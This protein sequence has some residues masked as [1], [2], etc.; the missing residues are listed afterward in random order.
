[1]SK[2]HKT[3][4]DWREG[5]KRRMIA[6]LAEAGKLKREAFNILRASSQARRADGVPRHVDGSRSQSDFTSAHRVEE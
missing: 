2:I 6:V 5:T 1:M 4:R 3:S